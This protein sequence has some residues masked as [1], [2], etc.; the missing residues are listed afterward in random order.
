MANEPTESAAPVAA[1]AAPAVAPSTESAAPAAP[2]TSPTDINPST[3][4]TDAGNPVTTFLDGA[5]PA[6][7][8]EAPV[9]TTPSVESP[10]APETPAGAEPAKTDNAEGAKPEAPKDEGNKSAEPAPLPVYEPWKLPEN[11]TLDEKLSTEFSQML[12]KFQND[13]KADQAAV[14][15]FGQTLVDRHTTALTDTIGRLHEAYTNAWQNQTDGWRESFIQDPEIGGKRQETTIRQANEFLDTHY[16]GSKEQLDTFR[17]LM[18]TTGLGVHPEMLRLLSGMMAKNRE[19]SP[20]PAPQPKIPA[21]SRT[22]RMYGK[23]TG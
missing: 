22:Q 21:P 13:T 1:P 23:K 4:Q 7:P 17:S 9:E 12:G 14:Q 3:G 19:G 8:T 6:L 16:P 5:P 11:I 18:K 10:A 15:E 2:T 20:V